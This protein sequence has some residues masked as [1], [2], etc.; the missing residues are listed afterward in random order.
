MLLQL[1]L[2]GCVIGTTVVIQAAFMS[3]GLRKLKAM[4]EAGHGMLERPNLVV[5][6]WVSFLLVPIAIDVVLWACLYKLRNALPSFE[7]A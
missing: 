2:A 3:V 1:L 7:E 4:E 5:V 6:I